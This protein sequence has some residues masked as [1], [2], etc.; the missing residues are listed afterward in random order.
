MVG[1]GYQSKGA[2]HI[3][4]PLT[5]R[6]SLHGRGMVINPNSRDLEYELDTP[7]KDFLY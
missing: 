6:I 1:D 3:R 7:Y 5:V 4:A 2:I